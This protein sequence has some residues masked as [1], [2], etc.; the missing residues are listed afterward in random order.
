MPEPHP[1]ISVVTVCYNAADEIETTIKSV[2]NQ[3][4]PNIEYLI[5]DGG[6]TDGTV[7]IIKKFSDKIAFWVSEKDKGIYDAMN[8]G[9]KIASGDFINFMNAGDYFYSDTTVEEAVKRFPN[10][11]DVIFGDSVVKNKNNNL[12][13]QECSPDPE[14]L[15]KTPTYRHGASFVN[16]AL[17]KSVPFDLSKKKEF[18]YGLDYNQIWNLHKM[19]KTF[20]KIDLPVLV[21]KEDGIS[22]NILKSY[23]IIFKISHQDKS[24]NLWE[25]IKFFKNYIMLYLKNFRN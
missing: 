11:T 21:Y 1:K 13:F 4:Y 9:I 6:S 18:D 24:P 2:I 5:I 15:K 19:G 3:S 7:D 16:L 17:H 20:K 25:Y 23:K 10:H 14:L 12:V 8:K 22:N